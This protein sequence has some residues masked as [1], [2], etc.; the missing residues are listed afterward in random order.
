MKRARET[1]NS[2]ELTV[3][4]ALTS[5]WE[6]NARACMCTTIVST[7]HVFS[8]FKERRFIG[9]QVFGTI[10]PTFVRSMIYRSRGRS[11]FTIYCRRWWNCCDRAYLKKGAARVPRTPR[12]RVYFTT[13]RNIAIFLNPPNI[14]SC[15]RRD[16]AF[17]TIRDRSAGPRAAVYN[18]YTTARNCDRWFFARWRLL[19]A[20]LI[21]RV[22]L[23][24]GGYRA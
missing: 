20:E 7:S 5:N 8:S 10:S 16:A 11:I 13:H 24:I 3:E 22:Q 18:A 6:K 19:T 14:R 12:A 17:L 23:L 15:I 1:T 21:R 4:A 2:N 9:H